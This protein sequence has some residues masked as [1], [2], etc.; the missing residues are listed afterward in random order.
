LLIV[1]LLVIVLSV[2][3]F[4]DSDYHIGIFKLLLKGTNSQ[5]TRSLNFL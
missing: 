5:Y 4:T 1:Y 2:L 3:G